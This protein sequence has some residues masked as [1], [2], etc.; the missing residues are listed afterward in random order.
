[1][2]VSRHASLDIGDVAR[3]L[4]GLVRCPP[5]GP[6]MHPIDD[7]AYVPISVAIAIIMSSEGRHVC[8]IHGSYDDD[9]EDRHGRT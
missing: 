9:K 1:M 5:I 8:V 3:Y 4:G 6:D 7:P 2:S